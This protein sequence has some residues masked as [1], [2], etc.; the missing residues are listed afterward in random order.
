MSELGWLPASVASA[1]EVVVVEN[2][3]SNDLLTPMFI[4]QAFCLMFV[5]HATKFS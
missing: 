5:D 3:A 1:P 2:A 4:T